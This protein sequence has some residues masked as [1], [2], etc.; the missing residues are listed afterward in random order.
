M[1]TKSYNLVY[2][3][4]N[5]SYKFGISTLMWPQIGRLMNCL[6]GAYVDCQI[7]WI[8]IDG[9]NII[10]EIVNAMIKDGCS[11]RNIYEWLFK[12]CTQHEIK[13]RR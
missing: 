11:E 4:S 8:I 3:D 2:I 5:F 7:N 1:V 12:L 9:Q 6:L 13:I 10:V